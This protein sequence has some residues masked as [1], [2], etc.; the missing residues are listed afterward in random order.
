MA[1]ELNQAKAGIDA[2]K[3]EGTVTKMAYRQ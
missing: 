3:S 2:I 1:Q